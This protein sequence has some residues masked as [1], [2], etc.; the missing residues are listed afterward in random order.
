MKVL[1]GFYS[2]SLKKTF[3]VG[4]DIEKPLQSWI[5]SGLVEKAKVTEKKEEK[6]AVSTKELKTTKETKSK[7]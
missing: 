1:K 5:D 7:K 2:N 4:E 3:K 6:K